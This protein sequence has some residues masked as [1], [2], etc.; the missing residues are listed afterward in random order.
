[1]HV[2]VGTHDIQNITVSSPLSGQV[3]VASDFL[4]G[5]TAMEILAVLFRRSDSHVLYKLAPRRLGAGNTVVTIIGVDSGSYDMFVYAVEL[6]GK[7][8]H[9]PATVKPQSIIVD[10]SNG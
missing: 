3:I 10:S 5:S 6:E 8:T 2:H 7:R 9:L 4:Q 1:M